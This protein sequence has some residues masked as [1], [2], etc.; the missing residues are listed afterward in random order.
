M[1]ER[2][3]KENQEGITQQ[4]A[5]GKNK[6]PR[7]IENEYMFNKQLLDAIDQQIPSPEKVKKPFW[8]V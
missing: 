3:L 8:F 1:K 2:Q 4:I 6:E 7:M 5:N